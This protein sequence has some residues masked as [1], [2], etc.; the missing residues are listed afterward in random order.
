[1]RQ[2]YATSSSKS[3]SLDPVLKKVLSL[4]GCHQVTTGQ[5]VMLKLAT[6][7][8]ASP[9]DHLL[10]PVICQQFFA[11]FLARIPIPADDQRFYEVFGVADRFYDA[12][13][14]QMKK[15]KKKLQDAVE[16]HTENSVKETETSNFHN[17]CVKIFKAFLLWFEET[18][19]NKLNAETIPSSMLE[20]NKLRLIFQVGLLKY[21]IF[22]K[23]D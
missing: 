21:L 9:V 18:Q 4:T 12:N 5:L 14:A 2:V 20:P 15:I 1:M 6:L 8:V 16:Y 10:F 11:L 17:G 23:I 7:I 22:K 3:S 19:L 13:T